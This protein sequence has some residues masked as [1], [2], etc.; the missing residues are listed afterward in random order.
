MRGM[1]CDYYGIRLIDSK[2]TL[3]TPEWIIIIKEFCS[4]SNFWVWGR[5]LVELVTIQMKTLYHYFHMVLF[6]FRNFT[7]WNLGIFAEFC[8]WPLLA[9]KWLKKQ[10]RC[11]DHKRKIS[12]LRLLKAPF[13]LEEKMGPDPQKS[14][15]APDIFAV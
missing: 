11:M 13:T 2:L 10:T 14:W 8:L 3:S 1:I 12:Y 6:F 5:N 15:Y 7:K 4:G 9:V